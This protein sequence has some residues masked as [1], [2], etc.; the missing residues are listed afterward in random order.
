MVQD[1][2]GGWSVGGREGRPYVPAMV[3]GEFEHT[4]LRGKMGTGFE[5]LR[6]GKRDRTAMRQRARDGL[7]ISMLS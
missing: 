4:G 1:L 2:G 6:M 7:E 5:K 3:L